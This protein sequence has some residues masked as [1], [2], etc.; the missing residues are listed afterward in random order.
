MSG[1]A[2]NRRDLALPR[3][4]Y[5]GAQSTDRIPLSDGAGEVIA[6]G[7]GVSE[8]AVGD[9]VV[10][11]NLERWQDGPFNPAYMQRDVGNHA[12]H[13]RKIRIRRG[14]GRVGRVRRQRGYR[15]DRN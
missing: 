4:L 1:C 6:I 3:G 15:E 11:A 2:L 5:G 10:S 7:A 13:R 9:I 14:L 12:G 8:V